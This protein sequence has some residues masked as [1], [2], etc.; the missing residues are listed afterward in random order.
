MLSLREAQDRVLALGEAVGTETVPLMEAFGRF[1]ADNIVSL[2][3]QPAT[4]MSAMDGYAVISDDE[5]RTWTV[6]GES[7]AGAP[8][9]RSLGSGDAVRIFTGASLPAGA[10]CVVIQE[11][12]LRDGD[13]IT[14]AVPDRPS[15]GANVRPLGADFHKG[16][17]LVAG[18]ER[19]DAARIGLIAAGGHAAV[20]VH[21]P[22]R[23]ALLSTGSELVPV[24]A[25][26]GTD[27]LPASNALMLQALLR[28]MPVVIDDLGIATD[29][30]EGIAAKLRS[31]PTADILVTIGGASVGDYDL[32][33]PALSALGATIDFWRVAM[34]PGKPLIA[35]RLQRQLF[36]GLPGNPVSAYVTALLFLKP[37]IAHLSGSASP[38]PLCERLPLG[39]DLPTNADRTDHLR[40]NIRNGCV[41]PMRGQDSAGLAAL[42]VA[43]ALIVRA[44][45]A[46][47]AAV[48][49]CVDV[50]RL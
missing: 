27:K 45:S 30:L 11:N 43:D 38:L 26:T 17:V 41:Y 44:P 37:L 13:R 21:R 50:I 49:E 28:D 34:R 1:T 23:V 31:S 47:P 46:P 24:G 6:V 33:R 2:R 19:L 20:E 15:A 4:T 48:G 40:A 3:S 18:G 10:D 36:L 9:P 42:A 7:A 8:Y 35:G 29:S 22:I 12:I 5:N 32:V 14:L 25:P 39:G 16:D